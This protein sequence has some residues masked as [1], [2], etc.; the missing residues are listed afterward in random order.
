MLHRPLGT[1]VP[2]PVVGSILTAVVLCSFS[3]LGGY[4][5]YCMLWKTFND[6]ADPDS[7]TEHLYFA[8]LVIAQILGIGLL[9]FALYV[10][11]YAGL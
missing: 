4:Y 2:M 11:M 1:V 5:F 9:V 7:W 6:T 10:A 3:L 8:G